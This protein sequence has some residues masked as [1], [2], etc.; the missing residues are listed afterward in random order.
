MAQ[1]AAGNGAHPDP[2]SAK[3]VPFVHVYFAFAAGY[4]L[5]YLLR[6]VNAV[7]SPE[8]DARPRRSTSGSLGLLTSA[9]F[10]AFGAMQIPAGM[11]LDRY[12]PRR[13]EPV[14]LLIARRRRAAR[15]RSRNGV[16]ALLAARAL[17]GAGVCGVPDGAA[18]GDRRVV[19]RRAAGVARRLDH[20][21]RRRRARWWRRRRSSSRCASPNWRDD[22]HRRS[23]VVDAS[24]SPRGSGGACRTRRS[25][26]RAPGFAA[27]WAGVRERVRGTRASGG[28]RRWARF[29]MGSFM[30]IQGLWSVPWLMEVDGY[31]RAE[32][33]AAPAGDE[34]RDPRRLPARSACSR[35]GSRG[36]ASTRGTC[37]PPASRSTS[38]A[39][40]RDRAAAA[41][42]ATSG[43]R[44]TGLGA[45]V[46]M[47][48]FT[49]LNEGFARELA[50]RANTALNL[51]MFVG[52]FVAQWGIGV[53]VDVGARRGWRA[54]RRAACSVAFAHR[55]RRATRSTYAWFALGWRRHAHG[56]VRGLRRRVLSL[57]MHLH[58]LGICGTFMGGIA[59]IAKRGRPPRHRL[60]RQ[61]LSADEHA[62]AR[63]W[64][65]SSP[66]AGT[67]RSST[68]SRAAPTC[69]SSATSSRAAIR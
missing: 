62:A 19:S 10:L 20:G 54:T 66:R 42:H 11:L 24:A 52:S 18:E 23:S 57:A 35:R 45:A 3:P 8:L 5:S 51:L 9:Y 50:G 53:V 4:L 59:A 67:R 36:A 65:S 26:R 16:P 29:G 34:R 22:L 46:N 44:C 14:L 39:L 68:A 32:R 25:R 64:A 30:A 2:M 17:I 61:R 33:R 12:G 1:P 49:V 15:S 37:S 60:R 55:A 27:Q 21:R 41:G 6:T 38:L 58:I 28:S 69:S 31:D 63:R 48:A 47:L 7:I 40:A 56:R 43:G 13:V